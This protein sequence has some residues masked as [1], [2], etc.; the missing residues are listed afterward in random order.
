MEEPGVVQI[1]LQ[2]VLRTIEVQVLAQEGRKLL[3]EVRVYMPIKETKEIKQ[4]AGNEVPTQ[5]LQKRRSL[6]RI[7]R[8]KRMIQ[9]KLISVQLKL[10]Q[11]N[12]HIVYV[13]R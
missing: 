4:R 6:K 2:A 7:L 1:Q 12:L 8:T 9:T 5:H 13:I 11:M 3:G 10:I